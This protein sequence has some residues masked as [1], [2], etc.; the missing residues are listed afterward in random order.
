MIKKNADIVCRNI[1]GS[2]F[3]INIT[4]NYNND[5]CTIYEI[6]DIGE[7]IWHQL[8]T[9]RSISDVV[10]TLIENINNYVEYRDIYEDAKEFIDTLV[11]LNFVEII[12]GRN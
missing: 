12:D 6:N 7:F 9:Q 8:E 11:S 1:H 10:D 3:L 5:L 4:E 2:I